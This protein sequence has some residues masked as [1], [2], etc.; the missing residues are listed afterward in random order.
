MSI[1]VIREGLLRR[2]VATVASLGAAAA[3]VT[4]TPTGAHAAGPGT[5]YT[6]GGNGYGQLGDGTTV[7]RLLPGP[8]TGR[9]DVTQ[10]H[11]GREHVI[12]LTSAGTVYTWG[13]NRQG[14]LGVGDL[15][16]RSRPTR[17]SALTGIKAVETGHNHS[18]ALRSDGTVW[19]WGLN[20]DGQ[21][22]DGTRT[23][24]K[25]PVRV[26]GLSN[27]T[28][29]AAGRNMT[30]AVKADGTVVAWGRNAEGQIGDGTTA[31]HRLVP[32]RVGSLTNVV[33]VAGGRDHGLALRSDG[34]VW[35]WGA[36]DYG[37]VGNG[38][39]VDRRLP[40][41]VRTGT[42]SL[43][44]QAVI[45]GA[46]HS[47]ALRSDG[48]VMSWGRNYR[49]NLGDGTT[50]Q[51][52]RPVFVAGVSNVASIG[53]GRDHGLAVLADGSV[54]AWGANAYGQLGD[55][56]KT[57]RTRAVVVS[58]LKGAVLAGG[59]GAQYSVVLVVP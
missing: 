24:R 16:S 26:A 54:R 6:W 30:Y 3:L 45:A 9:S 48:R 57:N 40:V 21:L 10:L 41:Q 14:Q 50:S 31:T 15:V 32:T 18:V 11:G 25:A 4:L 34:S 43:R 44:A 39:T 28:K 46:H 58:G 47:Y 8:V 2:T 12:A 23:N 37:Q 17:V 19:T 13:S 1:R 27:A 22:G 53:S 36:N 56:S 35:A 20:A 59:G 55:G 51:R 29:I 52:L 33:D 7:G 5:P 42:E 49:G 38:S